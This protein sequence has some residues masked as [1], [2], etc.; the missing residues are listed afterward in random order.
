MAKTWTQKLNEKK[1]P[2]LQVM[3]KPMAGVPAG[4]VLLMPTPLLLKALIDEIPKGQ[5]LSLKE[6]RERLAQVH[7]SDVACPLSTSAAVRVVAEAAWEEI[8]SGHAPD[9]VTPF[10]R[11]IDPGSSLA[12]KLTCGS[13]F[14]ETMRQQEE[15]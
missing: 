15:L 13:E 4:S 3:Q 1:A 6:L 5:Q 11:V 8:Q 14:L 7:N 10:W 12:K 2:K 9:R